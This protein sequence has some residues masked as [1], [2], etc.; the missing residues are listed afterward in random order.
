MAYALLGADRCARC[1]STRSWGRSGRRYPQR[2]RFAPA[3]SAVRGWRAG[4]RAAPD[5]GLVHGGGDDR[6]RGGLDF[7]DAC[8]LRALL[9]RHGA[10]LALAG[11]CSACSARLLVLVRPQLL[12]ML[13]LFGA[14]AVGVPSAVS[15]LRGWAATLGRGAGAARHPVVLLP[16]TLRN[17]AKMDGCVF[18]SANGG[19]N[20][21]IGTLPEGRGSFVPIAGADR[22]ARVPRGIWRGRQGPLL[23]PGRGSAICS[24]KAAWLALAPQKLGQLFNHNAMASS[25]LQTSNP[26]LISD[27]VGWPSPRS[28]PCTRDCSAGGVR[29]AI[30]RRRRLARSA[31]LALAAGFTLSPWG[32]VA[33]LSVAG[34]RSWRNAQDRAAGRSSFLAASLLGMCVVTHIVFFGAPRYALVWSALAG[35]A[36]GPAPAKRPDGESDAGRARLF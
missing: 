11:A 9:A 34:R 1:W 12:P 2:A 21:L 13:P 25:Y 36:A 26:Q 3:R 17:C 31:A 14:V 10:R 18:V 19:W 27:S 23:R 33:Q 24:A 35:V 20:L 29:R 7:G 5:V 4:R 6:S 30:A 8:R 16:W 28:R 22:A 32:Y 15:R